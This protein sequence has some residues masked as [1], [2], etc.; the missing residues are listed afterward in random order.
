MVG[1]RTPR[2]VGRGRIPW[3]VA[4]S[5]GLT[6]TL[7]AGV[8][9]AP[10]SRRNDAVPPEL[11]WGVGVPCWVVAVVLLAVLVAVPIPA[12]LRVHGAEAG[13]ASAIVV[14]ILLTWFLIWRVVVGA[15]DDRGFTPEQ[16]RLAVPGLGVLLALLAGF[17]VR[18][19]RAF[20]PE[21]LRR[22]ERRRRAEARRRR[23]SHLRR[24]R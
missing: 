7:V 14:G 18:C 20:A 24:R 22:A 12:S 10:P 15:D 21:R 6:A 13:Q 8:M 11:A 17:G 1:T 23:T 16:A 4:A 9:V 3:I 19:R 2:A 5:T